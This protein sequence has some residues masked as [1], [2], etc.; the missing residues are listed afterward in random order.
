MKYF[1]KE[2]TVCYKCVDEWG[3]LYHVNEDGQY[4]CIDGPAIQK[5]NGYKAWY[6]NNQFH[7]L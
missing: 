4:H 7:R 5:P 2:G 6:I 1:D 3:V